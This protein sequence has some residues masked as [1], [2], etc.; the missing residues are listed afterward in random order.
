ME[1]H[2]QTMNAQGYSV[3]ATDGAMRKFD[4]WHKV[5]IRTSKHA[6]TFFLF[7]H[8]AEKK[9]TCGVMYHSGQ[10]SKC[11]FCLWSLAVLQNRRRH[12]AQCVIQKMQ[13]HAH[14]STKGISCDSKQTIACLCCVLSVL[15]RSVGTRRFSHGLFRKECTAISTRESWHALVWTRT[16]TRLFEG[17]LHL[18]EHDIWLCDLVE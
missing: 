3:Y 17:W 7:L 8:H 16:V 9:Y 1:L 11:T 13:P 18:L 6:R 5:W 10:T 2:M 4:T 14:C 15:C 12:K